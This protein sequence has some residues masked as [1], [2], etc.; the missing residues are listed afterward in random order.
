MCLNLYSF[1]N[2]PFTENASIDF[3]KL[4]KISYEQ[5]RLMDDLVDLE[6]EKVNEII[7]KIQNDNEPEYLKQT[8]LRLWEKVRKQAENGRRTGS[9][10]TALA[11][12][13]AAM[14]YS[15]SSDEGLNLAEKVMSTKMKAELDCTIDLAI[16]RGPFEGWDNTKESM[17]GNF[18][19]GANS[20]YTNVINK[21]PEQWERMIEYGRRNVSWSTIAP[22]GSVSLLTDT[23]SGCEP[24]FKTF[25]TRRRR[26]NPSDENSRVDYI[27]KKGEKWQEYPVLH[28]KFKEWLKINHPDIDI[29]VLYPE[30]IDKLFRESPYHK[31]EAEDIDWRRRLEM[32]SILQRYTTNAI[33]STLNLRENIPISEVD[34][35]Y[36]AGHKLGLKGVTIF[37]EGSK[38]GVLVSN[39]DEEFVQHDA[40][41][42]PKDLACD[43]YHL[44]ARGN[45]WTVL[46]GLYNDKPY[47]VFA[48]E[49]QT[50][51]KHDKGTLS[52]NKSG[53][54]SLS[55]SEDE[56]VTIH[57]NITE[58]M[59]DVEEAMTRLISTALRHGAKIDF[60]VEQLEKTQG[61]ITS[62]SK[63]ISR[64]LKKYATEVRGQQC[65]DCGS[66]NIILEEGCST[67]VD[68]GS[69][70]CG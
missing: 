15:Y 31:N 20:F 69:S 68:C 30:E 50:A 4:Y 28:P 13:I 16:L 23:S 9:G 49:G 37:R 2:N 52:K 61:D 64:T 36:S 44:Q 25:H 34:A 1:V 57:P 70:K 24:V 5:Q 67:C 39:K 8:E 38:P 7:E 42:R 17:M 32:Q 48:L 26:I 62:F 66:S 51:K 43:I 3:D 63:A 56:D 60:I 40:P 18:N 10:I 12:M 14:N 33:S 65:E 45:R 35:I 6:I 54:Y 53:E 21:F 19:C 55:V 58:N 27:D 22:T 11:D 29:N 59:S 47:E 41:K 46:V